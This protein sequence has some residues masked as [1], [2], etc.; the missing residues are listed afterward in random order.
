MIP[1]LFALRSGAADGHSAAGDV[2]SQRTAAAALG[3][4]SAFGAYGGFVIPQ[5]LGLSKSTTGGYEAGLSWFVAA[6]VVLLAI[7]VAVA[8]SGRRRGVRI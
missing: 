4:V 7:A 1:T 8:V 6:Y 2:S 3:I 5:V